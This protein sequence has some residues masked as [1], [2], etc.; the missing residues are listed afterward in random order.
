[1]QGFPTLLIVAPAPEATV[2][3]VYEVLFL[4]RNVSPTLAPPG[5]NIPAAAGPPARPAEGANSQEGNTQ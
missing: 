2:A 5:A 3:Q 1:G 4:L